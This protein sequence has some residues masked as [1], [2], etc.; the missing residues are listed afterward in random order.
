MGVRCDPQMPEPER[1]DPFS[2]AAR[3]PPR[4]NRVMFLAHHLSATN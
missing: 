3:V 1:R 4:H 2:G